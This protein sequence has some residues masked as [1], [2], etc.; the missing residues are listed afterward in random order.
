[1]YIL[2]NIYMYV[3]KYMY[4]YQA[5]CEIKCTRAH[6]TKLKPLAC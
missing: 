6:H 4:V 5:D 1:M 2:H 3:K